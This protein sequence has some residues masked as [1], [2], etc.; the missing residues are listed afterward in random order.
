MISKFGKWLFPSMELSVFTGFVGY[1]VLGYYLKI[2]SFAKI[3]YLKI[4]LA[5]L[6]IVAVALSAA[7]TFIVSTKMHAVNEL[8]VRYLTPAVL[9]SSIAVFVC[10]KHCSW[11]GK[12]STAGNIINK[13]SYGIFLV[14]ILVL[15]TMIRYGLPACFDGI[16]LVAGL[17]LS[18]AMCLVASLLLVFAI[19]KLPLGKYVTH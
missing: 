19:S 9:F 4:L 5:L 17:P 7:G 3:K 1:L 16:W 12:L 8:F 2:K 13:Y 10:V 18:V 6:F 11:A 14:H 15:D